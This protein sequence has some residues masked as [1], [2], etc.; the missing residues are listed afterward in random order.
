VEAAAQAASAFSSSVVQFHGSKCS[1]LLIVVRNV[2]ED[3]GKPSPR[4]DVIELALMISVA[5]N[6]ARSAPRSDPAKSHDYRSEPRLSLT[7]KMSDI[8]SPERDHPNAELASPI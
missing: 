5:M 4:V 7:A 1:N 6:A 2:S 3:V 8:R